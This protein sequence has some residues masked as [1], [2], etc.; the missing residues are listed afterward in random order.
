MSENSLKEMS[1]QRVP[2]RPPSTTSYSSVLTS[3]QSGQRVIQSW[4][5][6]CEMSWA[7][8]QCSNAQSCLIWLQMLWPLFILWVLL[9]IHQSFTRYLYGK[10]TIILRAFDNHLL[11][12]TFW[13][14]E[15]AWV[16]GSP[17]PSPVTDWHRCPG[18]YTP[19]DTCRISV[20]QK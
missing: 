16:T 7:C 10:H 9:G 12:L 3:I 2:R 17:E 4:L 19:S 8:T 5:V 11:L 1:K 20:P 14:A 6:K 18:Q 13:L 15:A